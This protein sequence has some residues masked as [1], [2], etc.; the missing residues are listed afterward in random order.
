MGRG[1]GSLT[2]KT[3]GSPFPLLMT[4]EKGSLTITDDEVSVCSGRADTNQ[5]AE[6]EELFEGQGLGEERFLESVI[7]G[8][9]KLSNSLRV[10]GMSG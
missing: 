2:K 10:S 7:S 8:L 6:F 1:Q 3:V 4:G 5:V 9:H